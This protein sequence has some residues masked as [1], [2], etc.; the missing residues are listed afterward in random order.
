MRWIRFKLQRI[1]GHTQIKTTPHYAHLNQDSLWKL[2]R[3]IK[4]SANTA[5]YAESGGCYTVGVDR[6]LNLFSQ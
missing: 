3:N 4:G 2:L 6:L 5:G 1:L